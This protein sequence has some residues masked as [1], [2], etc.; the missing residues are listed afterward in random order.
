MDCEP[1][2]TNQSIS[3]CFGSLSWLVSVACGVPDLV[4]LFICYALFY[5]VNELR[6]LEEPGISV[7]QLDLGTHR[8]WV[9]LEEVSIISPE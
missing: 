1:L 2:L 3:C 9:V 5:K 6:F 8:W 7:K 4:T